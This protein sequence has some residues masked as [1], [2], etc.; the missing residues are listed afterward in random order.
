MSDGGG[1]Q[2]PPGLE[3]AMRF[4]W[5]N[6]EDNSSPR[7]GPAPGRRPGPNPGDPFIS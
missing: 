2:L 1:P 6:V 3:C 5:V 4:V 7:S